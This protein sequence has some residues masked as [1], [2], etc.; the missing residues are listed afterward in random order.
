MIAESYSDFSLSIDLE[1]DDTDNVIIARD[2]LN[3]WSGE[4][5]EVADTGVWDDNESLTDPQRVW[6][7]SKEVVE[8]VRFVTKKRGEE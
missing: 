1:W 8:W 4:Y 7:N 6:I 5:W 2:T 3:G